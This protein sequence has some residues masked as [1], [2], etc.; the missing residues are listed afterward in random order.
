MWGEPD[1][2][3]YACYSVYRSILLC[4]SQGRNQEFKREEARYA[5]ENFCNSSLIF[6]DFRHNIGC[7]YNY[8]LVIGSTGA[9]YGMWQSLQRQCFHWSKGRRPI[10]LLMEVK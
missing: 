9:L 6:I 3:C 10:G 1:F 7:E 4:L 2:T 8:R 5:A